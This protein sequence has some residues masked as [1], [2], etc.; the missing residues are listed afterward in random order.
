[1][2]TKLIFC[3]PLAFIMVCMSKILFEV[4]I[5]SVLLISKKKGKVEGGDFFF[6]LYIY[7]PISVMEVG[8]CNCDFAVFSVIKF[9][10]QQCCGCHDGL[11]SNTGRHHTRCESRCCHSWQSNQTCCTHKRG[12]DSATSNSDGWN[13]KT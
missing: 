7:G 10:C 5:K 1:M 12:D 8:A 13:C 4:L 2:I 6:G 9:T 11:C 3:T